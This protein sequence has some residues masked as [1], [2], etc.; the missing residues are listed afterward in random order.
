MS[1]LAVGF[2]GA[3]IEQA[4]V[5]ALYSAAARDDELNMT[6]MTEAIKGN[7]LSVVMSEKVTALRHWAEGRTVS[8]N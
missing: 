1:E 5:G 4:I 2:S 8:A 7:P 3:E 6:L